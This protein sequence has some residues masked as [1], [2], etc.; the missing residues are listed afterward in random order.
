VKVG[1]ISY[2]VRS[3]LDFRVSAQGVIW[4]TRS[5][6]IIEAFLQPP[7][8]FRLERTEPGAPPLK[9]GCANRFERSVRS[10]VRAPSAAPHES[11]GNPELFPSRVLVKGADSRGATPRRY[12]IQPA[13]RRQPCRW[14]TPGGRL[15]QGAGIRF[16]WRSGLEQSAHP[17][18]P[19]RVIPLSPIQ[20]PVAQRAF[21]EKRSRGRARAARCGGTPAERRSSRKASARPFD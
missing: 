20:S 16:G 17:L 4:N 8:R 10:R 12:Q 15:A 3:G 9:C 11:P 2:A 13:G 5:Y 1:R 19:A 18:T 21:G 6:Q 14:A 7:A